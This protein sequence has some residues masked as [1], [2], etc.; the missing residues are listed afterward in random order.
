MENLPTCGFSYSWISGCFFFIFVSL[1][2]KSAGAKIVSITYPLGWAEQSHST[3]GRE[4][5][6]AEEGPLRAVVRDGGTL[7]PATASS[8]LRCASSHPDESREA[9]VPLQMWGGCLSFVAGWSTGRE[10]SLH[11]LWCS[12]T[13]RHTRPFA[14]SSLA[15]TLTFTEREEG[16]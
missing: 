4:M 13:R 8:L 5:A 15:T 11:S 2:I 6:C 10:G 1:Q 12:F 16:F 14:G 7:V 3:L 9:L